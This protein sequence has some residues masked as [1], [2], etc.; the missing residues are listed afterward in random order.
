M[1]GKKLKKPFKKRGL[2][3]HSI[4][5]IMV[6]ITIYSIFIWNKSV[7]DSSDKIINDLGKFYLQEICERNLS[8]I[9]SE[10]EAR[11]EQIDS[12]VKNM[13]SSNLK[14]EASIRKYISLVQKINDLDIFALVDDSGLVYT[15]DSTFAGVSRFDFLSEPITDTTIYN[16]SSFGNNAM[17]I[18]AV[19]YESPDNCEINI[20]SCFSGIVINNIISKEQ[21][22]TERNQS[23]CELYSDIG[24]VIVETNDNPIGSKNLFNY[25]E[26]NADFYED[27]DLNSLKQ[28]WTKHKEG[29]VVYSLKTFG[30]THL[31]YKSVPGTNLIITTFLRESDINTL[32]RSGSKQITIDTLILMAIVLASIVILSITIFVFAKKDRDTKIE[33]DNERHANQAKTTF[34]FNMSHDIRTPMNAILGFTT[35]AKKHLDDK[36]ALNDYLNKIDTSSNVLLSIINNILEIARVESGNEKLIEEPYNLHTFE[37]TLSDMFDSQMKEKNIDFSISTNVKNINL[38]SD[39]TK[40]NKIFI[41]LVSN[42]YKYTPSGGKIR[43]VV[44]EK[45]YDKPGYSLFETIIIDTGI[46]MSKD[47]LP[48]VFDQFSRE[49]TSTESKII[50]T[51]LGMQIVKKYVDLMGGTINIDSMVGKGT[52]IIVS[53]PHKLSDTSKYIEPSVPTTSLNINSS[54]EKRI[55]IV[56]DNELNAEITYELLKE[57]GYQSDIASDGVI[58]LEKIMTAPA[59]YYDLILMDIQMPNLNGYDATR[60]IR[61]LDDKEKANI[62]I[63]AMTA[64]A[65]EE[66]KQT[67]FACGMNA[68]LSKPINTIKLLQTISNITG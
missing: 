59:H 40:L 51:G 47:F 42:A 8:S 58:C 68:H 7:N 20:K 49:R 4:A 24:E 30:T 15:A 53:I 64:N 37:K 5:S 6:A 34:L 25:Y 23:F 22:T 10:L 3:L 62:P 41:N 18:I 66:D 17:L 1:E 32:V 44:T 43:V 46:G 2:L 9:T 56:E 11:E 54:S 33:I 19:P 52:T 38:Y 48:H 14:D 57:S 16:I 26:D 28:D 55:L 50:G 60:K 21:L 45:P 12:A 29:Y 63:I 27:Y 36:E 39:T 35:L 61:N 67:A 31:Y 13:D 65:F